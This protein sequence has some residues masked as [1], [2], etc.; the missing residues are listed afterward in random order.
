V[1]KNDTTYNDNNNNNNTLFYE[2]LQV[3]KPKLT[4]F[5]LHQRPCHF[6][7]RHLKTQSHR[8]RKITC[9]LHMKEW[10]QDI[11]PKVWYTKAQESLVPSLLDQSVSVS[12][13]DF[14]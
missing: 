3:C 12:D 9:P 2:Q 10:S 14:P 13:F 11:S 5:N 4:I 7:C 6:D 8:L 1:K